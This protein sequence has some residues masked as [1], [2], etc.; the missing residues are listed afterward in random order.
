MPKLVPFD[1]EKA[2]AGAKFT[3]C[4]DPHCLEDRKFLAVRSDGCIIYEYQPT[5]TSCNIITSTIESQ[6]LCM[7]IEPRK[8]KIRLYK[9][10]DTGTVHPVEE[11]VWYQYAPWPVLK[12]F[13]VE[14]ND[15]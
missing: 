9:G 6:Y 8:I 15:V 10:L 14:Y 12:E 7:V 4:V 3:H 1:L 11:K 2:K 5:S 13:E